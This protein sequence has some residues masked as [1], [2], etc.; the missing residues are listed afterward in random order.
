M[1]IIIEK[2]KLFTDT[3]SFKNSVYNYVTN[4]KEFIKKSGERRCCKNKGN[5]AKCSSIIK[6]VKEIYVTT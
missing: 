5:K 2:T 4:V 1:T 3:N 6:N